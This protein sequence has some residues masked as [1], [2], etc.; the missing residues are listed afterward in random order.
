M[1]I[2][3]HFPAERPENRP[4]L[5]N[6][7]FTDMID[8]LIELD[9]RLLLL[10]NS[11]NT[12]W[13]DQFMMLFTGRFVWVPMYATILFILFRTFSVRNAI[14]LSIGIILAVAFADQVCATVLRPLFTRL[15][16][17]HPENP[18]SPLVHIVDG[19]R[20]GRYGFPSCH[21]SNS[22]ALATM[23]ALIVRN[24]RFIT[25]MFIWAAMNAYTRLY[26]GV[27]YPGD[28]LTGAI[29]G[30]L[31]A[32]LIYSLITRLA[33]IGPHYGEMRVIYSMPAGPLAPV[34]KLRLVHFRVFDLLTLT[35]VTTMFALFITAL[36]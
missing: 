30:A 23:L 6:P 36:T 35:G 7:D 29:I 18:I 11:L 33:D 24:R 1:T 9:T 10:F 20:G 4:G 28:L 22:F 19:Y 32:W 21:G 12:P 27:H 25:F 15:R 14:I 2:P 8:F 34:M 5:H 16:P 3:R 13:L 31:G 17:A 26:L